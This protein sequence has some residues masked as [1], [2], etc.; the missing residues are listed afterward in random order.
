[1]VELDDGEPLVVRSCWLL[2]IEN[3]Y[4]VVLI[5]INPKEYLAVPILCKYIKTLG[6]S[7]IREENLKHNLKY[8]R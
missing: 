6:I 1:M 3:V 7:G 8:I 4:N 5:F 2:L